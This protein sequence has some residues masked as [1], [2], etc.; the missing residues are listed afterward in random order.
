[1]KT[2][3][4]AAMSVLA[5][6]AFTVL[7]GPTPS[8]PPDAT[9]TRRGLV[10]VGTQEFGG[11]KTFVDGG[12]VADLKSGTTFNGLQIVT[13]TVNDGGVLLNLL[14]GSTIGGQSF[15]T[16]STDAGLILQL[17]TGSTYNGLEFLTVDAG[18]VPL[19]SIQTT[20]AVTLYVDPTGNDSNACTSTGTSACLTVNGALAKLPR[21]INH[22]V[23]L[24][25]A[26]GTYVP[27]TIGPFI[28]MGG[29]SLSIVG[30]ALA[31]TTVPSG[32]ATGLVGAYD[33]GA[34]P[35][36]PLIIDSTQTWPAK[37]TV[38]ETFYM[39]GLF[40]TVSNDAG[41]SSTRIIA[42]A[43]TNALEIVPSAFGSTALPAYSY[44]IQAPTSIITSASSSAV[45]I[46]GT[47]GQVNLT[48]LHLRMTAGTSTTLSVPTTRPSSG[49]RL[50]TSFVMFSD[51]G[52]TAASLFAPDAIYAFT[53]TSFIS[54]NS[55][56][57][58]SISGA[59]AQATFTRC[60]GSAQRGL[61]SCFTSRTCSF[62]QSKF[63]SRNITVNTVLSG[64]PN[65][66]FNTVFMECQA[67]AESGSYFGGVEGYNNTF[68]ASSTTM[69]NV[70]IDGCGNGIRLNGGKLRATGVL[71]IKNADASGY[72]SGQGV[73]GGAFQLESGA[74]VNLGGTSSLLVTGNGVDGGITYIFGPVT[75]GTQVSDETLAAMPDGGQFFQNVHGTVFRR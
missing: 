25:L 8:P 1:M 64:G 53:D 36:R 62:N 9:A 68:M 11:L 19:S 4:R 48:N 59:N 33:A 18:Y 6:L 51:Q 75:F 40:L 74:L 30:A 56:L 27:F 45:V 65:N 16:S 63:D 23:I 34:F 54:G 15:V 2:G 12:I 60:Y 21:F 47:S 73:P 32:T 29:V 38:N 35:T 66:T 14:P 3:V 69:F 61:V 28:I 31:P 42:S 39:R 46:D 44:A 37:W 71:E 5:L 17:M 70:S 43:D 58:V 72:L 24:N 22:N 50:A 52:N 10:G 13:T 26:A 55:S 57:A 41:V 49:L 67:R 20:A 7:A